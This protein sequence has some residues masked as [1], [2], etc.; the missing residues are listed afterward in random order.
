VFSA[1][2][3][4][5]VPGSA[6]LITLGATAASTYA[7][8]AVATAAG[9]A[10]V[11]SGLLSGFD[12]LLALAFLAASYVAWGFG[13]RVNLAANWLLLRR[14]GTSSNVI[15]KAAFEITG[16]RSERAQRVAAGAGYVV[17]ELAKE[18]PYY[19]GAFGAAVL[20]DAVSSNEA[21][22]FLAGANLG[23]AA[24]EYGLA[25]LTR[26]LLARRRT[27][28]FDTDWVPQEYLADYYRV[29]EP[30]ERETI[31]FFAEA[32]R[33][34][35]TGEPVLILGTGPTLHHVFLAAPRASEI[36]LA[37]YLPANLEE[38]E[39]WLDRDPAAHDWRAF[40]RYTLECEGL[41]APTDEDVARRE[42]LTRSKITRLLEAD[43]RRPLPL[44]R[45]PTV[46]SAYCAD[47]ATDDRSTWET[48]MANIVD[49]VG[50]DGLFITSALRRC[51]FY[52]VGDKRFPSANVDERDLRRVLERAFVPRI[53]VR[54]L[55]GHEAQGY[56]GVVLAYA[57]RRALV[58]AADRGPAA[59]DGLA[60]LAARG[61]EDGVELDGRGVSARRRLAAERLGHGPDVMRP[62][63]AADADVV[64][65]D[66]ARAAREVRHLEARALERLELDRE[67]S[68]A[69]GRL[70]RLE[71]GR[72]G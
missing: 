16:R 3:R 8:D 14:T 7:L 2:T 52:V 54:H 36:H 12:H 49:L 70:E 23:A 50:P 25:R 11:A 30:D 71:R 55:P 1:V 61:A 37:D 41:A 22:I 13:L 34:A 66:V 4:S 28:S 68:L 42:E 57:R 18:A 43:A 26:G 44:D 31:A 9:V 6:W 15:S 35:P 64:D 19:A 62:A 17:T 51:R 33:E 69:V 48:F 47:S 46:I 67:E 27:A 56:S 21:L 5:R 65:A 10:L 59:H 39:R 45:Y 29:V 58:G 53:E 24:Y 38:I 63:A 60:V 40:V 72:G 20:T 32:M